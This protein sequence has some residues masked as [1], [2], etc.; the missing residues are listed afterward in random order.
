MADLKMLAAL[1]ADPLVEDPSAF[2]HDSENVYAGYVQY[3]ATYDRLSLLGGVRV[4]KTDGTYRANVIDDD[5][6]D[7][8]GLGVDKHDYTNIF[9]DIN[10][11]YQFTD[12]FQI[13]AAFSTSIARPGFNQITAA[14]T[15]NLIDNTLSQGD[16]TL[17]PTTAQNY[18]L[19]AEYYFPNGTISASLGVFYKSFSDYIIPTVAMLPASDFPQYAFD[20]SS[21]VEVDSFSNIGSA[22]AEGIELNYIQQFTFL[23]AP[24][25]GLGFEGNMTYVDSRGAIRTGEDHKLPQTS[26]FNYN[27][28]V[29]YEKGPVSLRLGAS[30]VSR[31]LWAVGGDADSDLYSQPRFRL[32]FGS[33]Y[34]ITD[35]FELYAEVKNI[36]NTKLEFTQSTSKSYPIQ[37][38]IYD[39]DYLFGIRAHF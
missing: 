8:I 33:S 22:H 14:K 4:E 34:R 1:P 18:D 35:N 38:E 5:S 11:K 21:D 15:V 17:S 19:T 20:P 12:Q 32:D 30:Y 29:F 36:S 10:A 13:R 9:P 27:A 2:E 25:D 7:V 6:G 3:S 37:R 26:P 24:L 23:P 31:N 28:A 39:V 16:P